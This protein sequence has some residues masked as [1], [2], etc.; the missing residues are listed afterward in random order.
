MPHR[1]PVKT[2]FNVAPTKLQVGDGTPRERW[3]RAYQMA[4]F[5]RRI[6]MS[7]LDYAKVR[8]AIVQSMLYGTAD[9]RV[10]WDE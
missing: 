10:K 4:R 6:L 5:T 8:D 1:P 3:R 2:W 9:Y 7:K